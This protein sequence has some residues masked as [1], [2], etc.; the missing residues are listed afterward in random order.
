MRKTINIF[1]VVCVCLALFSCNKKEKTEINEETVTEKQ[2]SI[3]KIDKLP[4]GQFQ[5]EVIFPDYLG[6]VDDTLAMNSMYSFEAYEDQGDFYLISK[7]DEFDLYINSY[8]LD[9]S[10]IEKDSVY[11]IDFD[12]YALNGK[13]TIQVNTDENVEIYI[14]YPV[15]LEAEADEGFNKDALKL[16][17]DIIESD[18]EYGFSSAQLAIIRHGKLVY[19]NSWGYKS[20][21]DENGNRIENG[22]PVTDDTMYDLAS[23][24]KM[25]ATN[26]AV[27]KLVSEGKLDINDKVYEYLGEEFYED[28]LDFN[29]DFG[30]DVSYQTQIEWKK[31]LTVR[32][33]LTHEGGFPPSPRYFNIHVDAESQD[34]DEEGINVLYSGVE[35]S[36]LTREKTKESVNKTPLVY[37]PET[38]MMYSD[39]D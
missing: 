34:I 14:P 6:E 22:D 15:V 36:D 24:T 2:I 17:S 18:I 7:A 31:S 32:D 37:E 16:I 19:A 12:E 9:T 5:A 21:Y 3:E 1:L 38:E 33:M 28:T 8:K 4:D 26:Y 13:N 11:H 27:Q 23:V 39:V 20:S 29:Y 25:F 10:S 30:E 35:F